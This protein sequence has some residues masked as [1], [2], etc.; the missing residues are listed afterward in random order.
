VPTPGQPAPQPPT[1]TP[2]GA[3]N[4]VKITDY[5]KPYTG[6]YSNESVLERYMA[7]TLSYGDIAKMVA[8]GLVLP[9]IL[10]LVNPQGP[11][12]PAK[13]SYGPIP[14]TNWSSAAALVNPGQNPGWFAGGFP[15]PAYQT[16]N[17]YQAQFYWGQHPYVGANQPRETYNQIPAAA[18]TQGFGL[19]A[20]PGQ[21]DINQLL[22]QINQTALN[23]NFV[24]YN[25]Y[26]TQGYVP[27]G[28]P[29]PVSGPA[30]PP[31]PVASTGFVR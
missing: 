27:P 25:Q 30:I 20:G 2:P 14:P 28:Y 12:V 15:T 18:G 7:S 11:A 24:G 1:V 23:P 6:P 26:P 16:T 29:T 4:P 22:N 13:R 5:S 8:A 9:S 31:P 17:P 3:E 10:N 21:Y 19:Q